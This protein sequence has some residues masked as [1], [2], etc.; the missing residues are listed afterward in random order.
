[1]GLFTRFCT[2]RYSIDVRCSRS[3]RDRH[4]LSIGSQRAA[5]MARVPCGYLQG[6]TSTCS[7]VHARVHIQ[8]FWPEYR[9]DIGHP[10][11]LLE[12]Y[13]GCTYSPPSL[14]WVADLFH[15]GVAQGLR[16]YLGLSRV[17]TGLTKGGICA[18]LRIR[19]C[20][21]P[22]AL[23]AAVCSIFKTTSSIAD[24]EIRSRSTTAGS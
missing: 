2:A 6:R 22:P 23:S 1:M 18:D 3:A 15:P 5:H 24:W 8:M 17:T 13:T 4:R 14:S 20:Q 9:T 21:L 12:V 10:R 16:D 11:R 7:H 19:A